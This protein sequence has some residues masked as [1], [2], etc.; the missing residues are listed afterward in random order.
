M[1]LKAVYSSQEEIPEAHRELFSEK[2]GK[3]EIQV[4]GM[5]TEADIERNP[6]NPGYSASRIS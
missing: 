4:E 6:D 1:A 3:W 5:K 2:G